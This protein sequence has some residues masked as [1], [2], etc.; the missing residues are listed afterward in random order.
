MAFVFQTIFNMKSIINVIQMWCL[1]NTTGRHYV[2][3]KHQK[4]KQNKT[5]TF[6]RYRTLS[7][8]WVKRACITIV[9][10]GNSAYIYGVQCSKMSI[11][12]RVH[13]P[14]YLFSVF[15][16][17]RM[18]RTNFVL[19]AS[20]QLRSF[21]SI[22][23]MIS[24]SIARFLRHITHD[25]CWASVSGVQCRAADCYHQARSRNFVDSLDPQSCCC[26]V[27]SS[28]SHPCTFIG[29][30]RRMHIHINTYLIMA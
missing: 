16:F 20:L 30:A 27:V 12:L 23:W 2:L 26:I 18:S 28:S 5:R 9:M 6:V 21:P 8:C 24:G 11:S 22:S 4:Q 7:T 19:L 14:L 3:Q 17:V 1:L 13:T 29:K 15:V 25:K 10:L